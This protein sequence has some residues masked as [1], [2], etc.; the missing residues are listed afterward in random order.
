MLLVLTVL[1]AFLPPLA[2]PASPTA[3]AQAPEKEER[4]VYA[5]RAYNIREYAAALYPPVV[6]TLYLM[7]DQRN[8]V[9]PRRT[10][11]YYWPITNEYLADWSSRNQVV[12]GTLEIFQGTRLVASH[13]LTDYVI[14][15]HSDNPI[16]TLRLYEG[17]EA[18]A[19]YQAFV[20]ERYAYFE[21]LRQY[22]ETYRQYIEQL[23]EAVTSS[24]KG[25]I[26]Q[27][28]PE[29]PPEPASFTLLS[30]PPNRG[31]VFSLP[32]GQYRLHLRLPDGSV[33]PDSTKNLVVFGPRRQGIGY[34]VVP[35]AKWTV[36]EQSDAPAN[37][38]Y[39]PGENTLY[40]QPVF[41]KEYNEL[42]YMRMQ[43]PQDR[44]ARG[45]HW[46]WVPLK[47]QPAAHLEMRQGSQVIDRVPWKPYHV[48]QLPG[49]A[50]GYEVVDYDAATMSGP[51]SFW[52]YKIEVNARRSRYQVRL[53]GEDGRALP[54]SQREVR[55]IQQQ[56]IWAL[57]ALPF[58]PLVAGLVLN[59]G[60]RRRVVRLTPQEV[61]S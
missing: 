35:Q 11:V 32:Q 48:A 60:R 47:A 25:T 6:D 37:V 9:A 28:V 53:I 49:D 39:A 57:F 4:F 15:Y 24:Q 33:A 23:D 29:P 41:E 51:P 30:T 42:S 55:Q 20:D 10:L 31:F 40:L 3:W 16:E 59:F 14:Q 27:D 46:V 13:E 17:E 45:D 12:T 7:A 61:G 52:G 38:I 8:V 22:R 44:Q 58:I 50:L 5:V 36:A 21:G 26:P 54:G 18:P 1:L 2:A 43:E 19:R 56:N 34:V